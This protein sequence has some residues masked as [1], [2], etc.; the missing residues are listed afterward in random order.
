[1]K[2]TLQ[3]LVGQQEQTVSYF[4]KLIRNLSL[5]N[6]DA[7]LVGDGSGTTID[8]PYAWACFYLDMH[9][10]FNKIFFGCG[11]T[12]TNNFA[13][14]APYINVLYYDYYKRKKDVK[15]RKIEIVTDSEITAR[16]GNKEYSRNC[17][18]ILWANLDWL[19]GQG[20][21][22]HWNHIPRNSNP[23]S[24]A[25]DQIAGETRKKMLTVAKDCGMI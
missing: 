7:F 18:E 1:M 10:Q 9:S 19:K 22:I 24:L 12:G 11:S 20:Y 17:N 21:E 16:C 2:S 3:D 8:T 14:L 6:F 23:F 13:E 4:H 15:G 5:A 25:C